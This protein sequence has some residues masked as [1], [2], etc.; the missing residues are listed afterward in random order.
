M[1]EYADMATEALIGAFSACLVPA[2]LIILGT[3]LILVCKSFKARIFIHIGWCFYCI[4]MIIGFLLGAILNPVSVIS[5]EV[6]TYLDTA[7]N[8]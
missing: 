1:G 8:N 3:L 2:V 4:I 5:I 6:C 7:L